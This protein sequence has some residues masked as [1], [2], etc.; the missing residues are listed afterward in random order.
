MVIATLIS[1]PSSYGAFNDA[2]KAFRDR[3]KG[4]RQIFK[5]PLPG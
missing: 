3:Y 1:G 2:I 5:G 4:G